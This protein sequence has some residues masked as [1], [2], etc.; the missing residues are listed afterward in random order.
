MQ[1]AHCYVPHE[2]GS[3]GAKA[4]AAMLWRAAKRGALRLLRA[5]Q[6]AKSW[7]ALDRPT[8]K[9]V[10]HDYNAG[11]CAPRL[12]LHA[13]SSACACTLGLQRGRSRH[14]RKTLKAACAAV[15]AAATKE[16]TQSVTSCK[17]DTESFAEGAM[18]RCYRLLKETQARAR[19]GP[20][21][22][23]RSSGERWR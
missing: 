19:G 13:P 5:D 21:C 2:P 23:R 14:R 11:A 18:R 4:H 6:A 8:E 7:V 20:R 22:A 17:M 15:A 12:L 3:A 1:A 10:R 9:C 16:W